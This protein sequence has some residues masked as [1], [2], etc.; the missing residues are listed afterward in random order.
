[1]WSKKVECGFENMPEGTY[2][3]QILRDRNVANFGI[4]ASENIY[5]KKPELRF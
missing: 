1:M 3:P 2:F 4:N 5:S